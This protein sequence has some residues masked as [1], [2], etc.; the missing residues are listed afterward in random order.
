MGPS[1]EAALKVGAAQADR[2]VR[3]RCERILGIIQETDFQRRL[4]AFAAG[5]NKV[6]LPAWSRF[7]Q[8]FGDN[9]EAR[10]LFVEML[11]ADQDLM[12]AIEAGPEGVGRLVDQRCVQLQQSQRVQRSQIEVGTVA[13]LLFAVSDEGVNCNYQS[14]SALYSLC[15]QNTFAAAIETG[16]RRPLLR[17]MLGAWIRRCDS[18]AA[19]QCLSLAMRYE[20]KEGL[21]PAEKVVGNVANQPYVR[22]AGILAIAKLGDESHLPL[23]EKLLEDPSRISTQRINNV[24]YET[25]LRDIALAALLLLK[26]QDP[27]DFGFDRF[28]RDPANAFITSTVGFEDEAKRMVAMEKW[29]KFAKEGMTKSE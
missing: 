1:A 13:G 7:R 12:K 16:G 6:E 9:S 26:Q 18:W 14:S 10:S 8:S 20:L 15:Y 19:Y 5:D 29:R 24:N 2:E 4:A 11:K 17:Q 23:L 22:Q 28:Q 21:V 25:Q 3:Y 27:K